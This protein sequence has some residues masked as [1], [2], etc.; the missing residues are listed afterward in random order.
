M[1]LSPS[2][3]NAIPAEVWAECRSSLAGLADHQDLE[4]AIV[5]GSFASGRL[6]SDSDLDIAVFPRSPLTP[7]A[8][9]D[10]SD[11]LAIATGRPIDLVDLTRANGTLLRQILC[12]G[13]VLFSKQ[14]GILGTLNE[15]LLDWQADFEPAHRAIL[16]AQRNRFLAQAHGS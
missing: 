5:F 1:R 16:T 6:R 13:E 8:L 4:L 9:Q 14:P 11:Q 7:A 12:H 2:R 15:R 10:I 3:K